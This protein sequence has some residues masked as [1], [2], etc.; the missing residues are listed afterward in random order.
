MR[1]E[2]ALALLGALAV[3]VGACGNVAE[4]TGDVGPDAHIDAQPEPDGGVDS[5]TD[6]D[7]AETSACDTGYA[8]PDCDDCASGYQDLD[9]D[10]VCKPACDATGDLA[11]DC[12]FGACEIDAD[13]DR[14]CLCDEGHELGEQGCE[15]Y[16]PDDTGLALWLDATTGVVTRQGSSAVS[17]WTDRRGG[18]GA[19]KASPVSGDGLVSPLRELSALNDRTVVRFGGSSILSIDD[20]PGQKGADYTVLVVF[21]PSGLSNGH[22]ILSLDGL[23]AGSVFAL[24]RTTSPAYRVFH[25]GPFN[26]GLGDTASIT[27]D[28]GLGTKLLVARRRTSSAAAHLL[29]TGNNAG[30]LAGVSDLDEAPGEPNLGLTLDL[31]IGAGSMSGDLAEVLIYDR[32]VPDDELA[33]LRSYLAAKWGIE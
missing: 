4:D 31:M 6:P 30:D 28:F 2:R 29:L 11:L 5:P 12:G 15:L 16:T 8:G 23:E 32:A 27:F 1:S 13:G 17:A 33:T 19:P 20:F 18:E 14:V 24:Q 10:G 7:A 25:R 21:R 22:G 9:G 26:P 3:A